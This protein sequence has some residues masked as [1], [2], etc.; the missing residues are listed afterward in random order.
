M[1]KVYGPYIEFDCEKCGKIVKANCPIANYER[2]NDLIV[3]LNNDTNLR[4]CAG[5]YDWKEKKL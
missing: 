1:N 2:A 5:C 3:D 4:V